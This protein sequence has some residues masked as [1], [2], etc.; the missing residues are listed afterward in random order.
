MIKNDYLNRY[1]MK[2]K[3][4][5]FLKRIEIY[6]THAYLFKKEIADMFSH[7]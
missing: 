6:Y 3:E 2:D 7:V 5:I 4:I 1:N